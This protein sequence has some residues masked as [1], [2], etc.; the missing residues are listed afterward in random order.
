MI[1]SGSVLPNSGDNYAGVG[2][3][4]VG[5]SGSLKFRTKPSIFEVVADAFF[6]GSRTTQFISGSSGAVEISSSNFHLTPQGNV[7]MSGIITACLLYTSP[8]PRD[9]ISSRMPS[10]A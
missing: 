6:V 2:L 10:S 7:T 1:Y 8:S 9:R 4:L 5:A 3:E